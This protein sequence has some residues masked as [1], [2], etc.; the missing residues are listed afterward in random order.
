MKK[1]FGKGRGARVA[2]ATLAI[3]GLTLGVSPAV[4]QDLELAESTDNVAVQDANTQLTGLNT[5]GGDANRFIVT[6]NDMATVDQNRRMEILDNIT[7]EFSSDASFVREM[8]DGSY[9]VELDPP[10]PADRVPSLRGTLESKAEIYRADIDFKQTQMGAPND[11]YYR[12]QWHLWDEYGANVEKAWDKD[13]YGNDTVI[14][15]VDS[16]ITDHP[17]LNDKVLPGY[18]FIADPYVSQDGDER[19]A[20]PADEGDWTYGNECGANVSAHD[21]VWHGTHVA[22]IAAAITD[23]HTGV[24]GVAP[25]AS[26]LPVRALGRCGGYVSDIADAIAWS[27]GENVRYAPRNEHPADVINLSLG[28]GRRCNYV[29]QR[30]IDVANRNGS[31]IA[32][33]AG[34]ENQDANNVQP[35]SCNGVITVGATGPDGYRSA[36]SNYG[37]AVDIAAPGGNTYPQTGGY[38]QSAGILSTVNSGTRNPGYAR[39]GYMDGTSMATPV[40]SGV[41]ALMKSVNPNLRNDQI[42]RILRDTSSEIQDEPRGSWKRIGVGIVNAEGAVCATLETVGDSCRQ[43]NN[44]PVRPV[45]APA[46]VTSNPRAPRETTTTPRAPRETT[47]TTRR[48][49]LS[50]YERL[51]P[52]YSED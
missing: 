46:P 3:V 43:P 22:G 50:I 38:D 52:G 39:I 19:D 34:N 17:D 26:I 31:T 20:D 23:N 48:K 16:G 24:A 35:A 9:V 37:S 12:Q 21:S 28:G 45:P 14:A 1:I 8:Y 40:V 42:E 13:V 15:V 2:G 7:N 30:A 49:P 36:Y 5:E 18:D 11:Q 4:A 29:Y 47:P 51:L 25:N 33:A 6:F 41:I 27:S 44:S 32:V 10:V